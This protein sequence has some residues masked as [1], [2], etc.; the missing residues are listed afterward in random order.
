MARILAV[1]D[2][3]SMTDF[4]SALLTEAGYEVK[5]APDADAAMELY[6]D[7]KPELIILDAQM[8]AGGG[9]KVFR[10]ART[11]LGSETPVI[12]VTGLPERVIDFA[13]AQSNVRVFQKPVKNEEL[14]DAV[15]EFLG[16]LGE[17]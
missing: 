2:E 13:L 11:L 14:L 9:E 6:Y 17:K 3:A 8:P 1:D 16:P 12:F 5:T 4:Y 15:A 10:I 7:F